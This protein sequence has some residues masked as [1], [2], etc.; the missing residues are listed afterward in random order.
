VKPITL[1][2]HIVDGHLKWYPHQA[3]LYQAFV[4]KLKEGDTV[5]IRLKKQGRKK[6][7][8]QLGYWYGILI[9]CTIEGLREV[10]H[11]T[12]FDITVGEHRVG[13][14]TDTDTTDILLKTLYKAHKGLDKLPLKRNMTTEE[15]SGL[16]DFALGWVAENLG[17]FVPAPE[18]D[19]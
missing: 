4:N 5:E 17:V 10:G 2:R 11:S 7:N 16:I 8:P 18:D 12:L 14:E 3:T 1:Y 6:T 9:P 13:V 15:M 19:Q